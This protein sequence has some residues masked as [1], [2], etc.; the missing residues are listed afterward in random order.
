M[1]WF[2][3]H[4]PPA[5]VQLTNLHRR[6][7]R[8]SRSPGPASRARA[9]GTRRTATIATPR[10]PASRSSASGRCGSLRAATAIVGRISLTGELGYE[11]VVPRDHHLALYDA[12][13]EAGAPHGLRLSA[14]SRSTSCASRRAT[15]S[16]PPSSGTD[17][18]PAECG[19]DRYRRLRQGRVRRTRGGARERESGPARRL[20]LLRVDAA[21]ADAAADDPIRR[22]GRLVGEV[23]SGGFGHYVGHEPRARL[24][25]P[26]GR[27]GAARARRWRSWASR[28]AHGSCPRRRT[29]RRVPGCATGDPAAR[30]WAVRSAALPVEEPEQA[31]DHE[32]RPSGPGMLGM[33]RVDQSHLWRLR[34]GPTV[35]PQA[36]PGGT[37]P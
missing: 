24:R 10:A 31:V 35:G 36:K 32:R 29:T 16:G 25:G 28:G 33:A 30:G 14:I 23:T 19:L 5:G 8:A 20:V 12:L 1:R 26:R 11:V 18:T 6:A 2:R 34:G 21:D 37:R 4:L 13:L 15:A 22:D 17:V 3:A 27:R 9:R 7:D